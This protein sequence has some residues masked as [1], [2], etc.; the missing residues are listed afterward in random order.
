MPVNPLVDDITW[1]IHLEIR[2]ISNTALL[3]NYFL[4]ILEGHMPSCSDT[5]SLIKYL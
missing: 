2:P 1:D 3:V 5:I 4:F